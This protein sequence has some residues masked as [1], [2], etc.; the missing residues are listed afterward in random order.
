MTKLTR[1]GNPDM[2]HKANMTTPAKRD[3][4]AFIF[5]RWHEEPITRRVWI[6]SWPGDTFEIYTTEQ[7][8]TLTTELARLTIYPAEAAD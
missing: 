2:R 6:D 1:A 3:S 8:A 7:W 5:W 4:T